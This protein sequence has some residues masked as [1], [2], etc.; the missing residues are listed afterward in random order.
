MYKFSLCILLLSSLLLQNKANA[1]CS[2]TSTPT[3]YCGSGD[4]INAFSLNSIASTGSNNSCPSNGYI[5]FTQTWSLT[6]GSTYPWTASVG[7]GIYP[8]GVAIWIDLNNNGQYE[9]SEMVTAT[10]T[11]ALTHSGNLTVPST[12]TAA[13]VRMRV[14]CSYYST[15][16]SSD[17]CTN[18][19]GGYGETED[20]Y[21]TL[22]S[23]CQGPVFTAHPVDQNFC[24]SGTASFSAAAT[25]AATYRWQVNSGSGYTDIS[26]NSVYSNA[27]TNALTLNNIPASYNSYLYRL[28]AVS[29]CGT[30]SYSNPGTLTFYTPVAITTQ[31]TNLTACVDAYSELN[32]NV[33]GTASSYQWQIGTLTNGYANI[34]AGYPY[35]GTNSSKLEITNTHDTLNGLSFRCIVS[36]PCTY[37]TSAAIP[38]DVI[39]GP[40]ISE[41]PYNDTVLPYT[42]AFFEVK[43][44]GSNKYDLY[45][46]ASTDNGAT[47]VNINNNSL[48]G[49]S[50][51]IRLII[52][53]PN[54]GLTGMQFRCILKSTDPACGLSRDTSAPATLYVGNYTT[55]GEVHNNQEFDITL[56][57]NPVNGNELFVNA[58]NIPVNNIHM[59][60]FDKLGRMV[61]EAD[62]KI[63]SDKIVKVP[64]QNIAPG[65][66]SIQI[67]D[68]NNNI[69][70]TSAF[71]RQ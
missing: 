43:T 70:S 36:G 39:T 67:A 11:W 1:Q 57:P 71:T 40:Y 12:A 26:N 37:D 46:Q 19:L 48:Y 2:V 14:R 29:G 31:T 64:V 34:P 38:I 30:P 47:F 16:S 10:A 65:I 17:A 49:G 51:G 13:T 25:S 45:W 32:V 56:Y 4:M 55:V 58:I 27:T 68:A 20:S 23:P 42:N 50:Q 7:S 33:S 60:V 18:S 6:I 41:D 59:R 62:T 35:I 8:Q 44:N 69:L 9:N 21:V 3:N 15:I 61:Y 28:K 66:Y 53:N 5:S 54:P 24:A 22:V 52:S 63:A